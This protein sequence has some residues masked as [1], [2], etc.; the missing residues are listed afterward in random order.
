MNRT[1]L[2]R[3]Y[4]GGYLIGFVV[5][6]VVA[7]RG[8]I[9]YQGQS[10]LV[11]MIL[12][13]SAYAIL[14]IMEPWLSGHLS[15]HQFM[16]F[17]L[18][19]GLVMVLT[20]LRPFTDISTVLYVPLCIQVLRAFSRRT[21]IIWLFFFL[22]LL[23]VTLILG[24]DL[25]EGLALILLDLAVGSFLISYDFLYA[26]TQADQAES[27]RLLVDLQTAHRQL[28]EYA[29][30][31]EELAAARERNRLARELHDSVSQAIFSITLTS[32]SARLLLDREPARVSEQID[33][34]QRMTGDALSQL[35]S[36]I[37]QLRPPQNS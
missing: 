4:R 36:L 17:P 29:D 34:L 7:L 27:R 14:Y 5:I 20:S 11:T 35:R 33:R 13:V 25:F 9:S 28:Q 32:Q 10:S 23:S 16:Y 19:T 18:Q 30:Q 15:W 24:M 22:S 6:A 21:A 12:L 8:M 37:A 2:V 3:G 26:S 31:A 1:V